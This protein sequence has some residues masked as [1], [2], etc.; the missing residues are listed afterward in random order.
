MADLNITSEWPSKTYH[1]KSIY[2]YLL[3][4][5]SLVSLFKV[6]LKSRRERDFL[7]WFDTT[8]KWSNSTNLPALWRMQKKKKCIQAANDFSWKGFFYITPVHLYVFTVLTHN[9]HFDFAVIVTMSCMTRNWISAF[10][11]QWTICCMAEA[12]SLHSVQQLPV[13]VWSFR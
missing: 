11:F 3:W 9:G 7:Q 10:V 12:S 6:T 2:S 13:G 5:F 8:E 4:L 1:I